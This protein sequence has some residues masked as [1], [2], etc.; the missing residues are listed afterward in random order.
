MKISYVCLIYKSVNW[1]KFVY[2]QF[3]K[4]TKLNE[5]DEFYFVAND[6]CPDVLTYLKDNN[7]NHYIHNNK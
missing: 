4:Y 7:I 1:L 2:K 6:S 3:H 5:G